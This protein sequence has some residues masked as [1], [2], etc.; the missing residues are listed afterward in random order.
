MP[1]GRKEIK[2]L[3]PGRKEIK[4]LSSVSDVESDFKAKD[5]VLINVNVV[6]SVTGHTVSFLTP[7]DDDSKVAVPMILVNFKEDNLEQIN[8]QLITEHLRRGRTLLKESKNIYDKQAYVFVLKL[9]CED[10]Q[11]FSKKVL[12]V[13]LSIDSMIFAAIPENHNNL[14]TLDR[15]YNSA[16]GDFRDQSSRAMQSQG[17]SK[18]TSDPKTL[19][20]QSEFNNESDDESDEKSFLSKFFCC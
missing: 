17:Q 6:P 4:I 20:L 18:Q 15:V 19:L 14:G 5:I 12:R 9:N 16:L 10:Y 11:G 3:S 13:A 2:T 7:D 1:L 8:T